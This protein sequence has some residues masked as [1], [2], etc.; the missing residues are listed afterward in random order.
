[1]AT[2]TN[3]PYK[4]AD[5]AITLLNRKAVKRFQTAKNRASQLDFDELNVIQI[6]RELYENLDNDNRS[7]FLELAQMAYKQA[8]PRG[9]DAPDLY[10]LNLWLQEYNPVTKYQYTNEVERKRDRTAEAINASTA[11]VKEF[12][13]GL[14]YWSQ[15]SS[16]YAVEIVDHA[17][18][19]AFE[20]AGVERVRWHTSEDEKVCEECRSRDNKVYS[21]KKLPTK[22]HWN[23]RCFITAEE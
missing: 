5:K 17:T 23:C 10:L 14:S 19:R 4:I 11:K 15:M 20:D 21:I 12:R 3:S 18:I 2:V 9:N 8:E 13:R 7:A 6:C 16:Q 1:M 22:P